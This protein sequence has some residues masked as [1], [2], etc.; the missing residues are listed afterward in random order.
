MGE[1]RV[2]LFAYVLMPDHV[3]LLA[4]LP[5]N[6]TLQKM[7]NHINGAAAREIN[8]LCGTTGQKFWQGG[9]YD[10]RIRGLTDFAVKIN[11][12]HNNPVKAGLSPTPVKYKFSSAG[13]YADSFGFAMIESSASN[14]IRIGLIR[15][16]VPDLVRNKLNNMLMP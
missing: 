5:E 2:D 14:R 8:K 6:T 4:R 16:T 7:M 9:F 3:H 12:I 10:V 13:V 11:Y 15:D 1:F